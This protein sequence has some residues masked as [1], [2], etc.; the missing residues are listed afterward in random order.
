MQIVRELKGSELIF[1]AMAMLMGEEG[2]D[3]A[4]YECDSDWWT[5]RLYIRRN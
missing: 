5:L 4:L 2:I 1:T 3:Y